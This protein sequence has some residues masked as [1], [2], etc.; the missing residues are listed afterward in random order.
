MTGFGR[1]EA[2]AGA[3]LLCV[4]LRSVNSR[5]REVKA[6]L[7][8][9]LA[10]LE[11]EACG[12]VG[13]SF[14]RGRFDLHVRRSVEGSGRRVVLDEELAHRYRELA[15]GLGGEVSAERLLALPGVVHVVESEVDL[16]VERGLLREAV[17]Q[18]CLGLAGMRV[19]E[20]AALRADLLAGLDAIAGRLVEVR[21][22]ASR[23]PERLQERLSERLRRLV[24]EVPVDSW[25][26]AQEVALLADRADVAEELARLD[27]HL[28][29]FRAA[30]G[31]GGP[32]GV[33]RKLDFLLQEMNREVNTLGSKAVD[34]ELGGAVVDMKTLL[35]R[36]REQ[37][38]NVE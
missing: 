36:L 34:V 37:V 20:G 35:E 3:V 4:E 18:A 16:E 10:A 23:A 13:E 5:F 31:A 26:L 14:A 12:L 17:A 27:S 11:A 21:E 38:A 25:R 24:R 33:G 32:A 2:V 8:R 29:Q 1:G 19:A 9:E 22:V 15:R 30:L 28:A 7:P 6:R